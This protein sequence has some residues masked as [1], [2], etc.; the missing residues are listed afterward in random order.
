MCKEF[1]GPAH[2]A[3]HLVQ[4]H[5]NP[6]LITKIAQ[7]FQADIGQD[8]D[9]ALTLNRFYHDC[10]NLVS[11]GGLECVMVT[12]FQMGETGQK[13]AKALGHFL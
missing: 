2:P 11:G 8:P 9:A 12:K 5:Q 13:R 6:V 3:L 7:A 10:R 1:P 4:N